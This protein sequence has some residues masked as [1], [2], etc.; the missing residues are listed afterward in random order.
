MFDMGVAYLIEGLEIGH[1]RKSITL[2]A[3][4]HQQ[5]GGFQIY[6]GQPAAALGQQ[7]PSPLHCA[8]AHI[9]Y[10]SAAGAYIDRILQDVEEH[11]IQADGSTELG[12]LVAL[13]LNQMARWGCK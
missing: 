5:F 11:G 1:P 3:T 6:F 12:L 7:E 9:L 2:T 8:I 4:I 10:L 13:G